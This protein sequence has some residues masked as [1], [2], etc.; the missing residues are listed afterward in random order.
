MNELDK[1]F[2]EIKQFAI[3]KTE[4]ELKKKIF[5]C[6]LTAKYVDSLPQ[7]LLT[8]GHVILH[9]QSTYKKPYTDKTKIKYMHD[10]IA[11]NLK[12]HQKIDELDD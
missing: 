1:R 6:S 4:S 7:N 3:Q 8:L 5:N 9:T 11:L 10:L 2:A 12:N